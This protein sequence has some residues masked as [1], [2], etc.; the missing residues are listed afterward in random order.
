MNIEEII[1]KL[2]D[3]YPNKAIFS[4]TSNGS[5]SVICEVDPTF[6]HP[7]Y[8]LAVCVIGKIL[9]HYHNASSES[10]TVIRGCLKLYFGNDLITLNKGE[11]QIISPGVIHW[12]EGNEAWFECRSESGWTPDDHILVEK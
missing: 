9:P 12:A 4:D 8:S 6:A 7:E 1:I 11:T 10:F 3:E 5:I 2:K